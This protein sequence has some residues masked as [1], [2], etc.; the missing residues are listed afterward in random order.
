MRTIGIKI[1]TEEVKMSVNQVNAIKKQID[2]LDFSVLSISTRLDP[3][4][5]RKS[6]VSSSFKS[7]HK[8]FASISAMLNNL[9]SFID[10]SA[11]KYESCETQVINDSIKLVQERRFSLNSYGEDGELLS[12]SNIDKKTKSSSRTFLKINDYNTLGFALQVVSGRMRIKVSKSTADNTFE[13]FNSLG[14]YEENSRKSTSK[15]G[16]FSSFIHTQEDSSKE[17]ENK[18]KKSLKVWDDFKPKEWINICNPGKSTKRVGAISTVVTIVSNYETLQKGDT[19]SVKDF[20]LDNG[21]NEISH[22]NGE[23]DSLLLP[24]VGTVVGTITKDGLSIL[25]N[26]KVSLE[27][28]SSDDFVLG[29]IGSICNNVGNTMDKIFW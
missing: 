6:Y 2:S 3:K 5:I 29:D 9:S 7:I 23:K 4:I 28:Y 10:N 27:N 13:V 15:F 17:I 14:E 20:V 16:D 11:E 19:D 26:Q 12:G 25:Q 18:L 24:P 22:N 21:I 1:N 8:N